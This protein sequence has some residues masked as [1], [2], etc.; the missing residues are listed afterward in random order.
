MIYWMTQSITSS[1]RLYCE[2]MRAGRFGPADARV[3]VPT[4]GAIFPK[5]II[6]PPRKWAEHAF[7]L[8]RWTKFEAG[9]HFAALEQPEALVEDLRAFYRD[10]RS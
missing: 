1:T 6:R 4:A 5:E 10:L 8:R 9:G 2:T 3:E 7:D